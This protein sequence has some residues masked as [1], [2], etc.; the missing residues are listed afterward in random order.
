MVEVDV[1][2]DEMAQVANLEPVPPERRTQASKAARGPAVDEGGLVALEQV[3]ADD[4]LAAEMLEIEELHAG[5]ATKGVRRSASP[6]CLLRG[7]PG[8]AVELVLAGLEGHRELGGA[9]R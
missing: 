3:R 6:P 4:V 1:R 8:R 7:A 9:R 5:N 2:E